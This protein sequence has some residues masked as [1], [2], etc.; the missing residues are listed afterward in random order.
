MVVEVTLQNSNNYDDYEY[1]M[2]SHSSANFNGN[3]SKACWYPGRQRREG[4]LTNK[5][6]YSAKVV[7]SNVDRVAG[8]VSNG[9]GRS[10]SNNNR[11]NNKIKNNKQN[12]RTTTVST[13]PG[14]PGSRGRSRRNNDPNKDENMNMK[15]FNSRYPVTSDTIN[16]AIG[17]GLGRGDHRGGHRGGG[18]EA[19]T[20]ALGSVAMSVNSI[21][22]LS[23]QYD[24]ESTAYYSEMMGNSH[25]ASSTK[26]GQSSS[27]DSTPFYG[28]GLDR[29]VPNGAS[30]QQPHFRRQR[31]P[32]SIIPE[33]SESESADDGSRSSKNNN[34]E[35]QE[36]DE[37]STIDMKGG[38]TRTKKTVDGISSKAGSLLRETSSIA[39]VET[40]C[41]HR[42]FWTDEMVEGGAFACFESVARRTRCLP[43]PGPGPAPADS[44]SNRRNNSSTDDTSSAHN[45]DAASTAV[46]A[47]LIP[48]EFDQTN[49]DNDDGVTLNSVVNDDDDDDNLTTIEDRVVPT[50]GVACTDEQQ[51]WQAAMLQHAMCSDTPA[52]LALVSPEL[53]PP[54][55]HRLEN[56][57][58]EDFLDDESLT[59]LEIIP[60]DDPLL[61]KQQPNTGY[62]QV[63]YISEEPLEVY[64]DK[65][66]LRRAMCT[67]IRLRK[68]KQKEKNKENQKGNNKQKQKQTQTLA[69]TEKAKHAPKERPVRLDNST[70][71]YDQMSNECSV[72]DLSSVNYP[73]SLSA[74][75][76]QQNG[77]ILPTSLIAPWK[78][79]PSSNE[80]DSNEWIQGGLMASGLLKSKQRRNLK[81][82]QPPTSRE[83]E[84][85]LNFYV[86][87]E[88]MKEQLNG[89][90]DLE[91]L[92]KPDG[93]RG[94][95]EVRGSRVASL[96]D[97]D[98]TFMESVNTKPANK[99]TMKNEKNQKKGKEQTGKRKGLRLPTCGRGSADDRTYRVSY[100]PDA[101]GQ[102]STRTGQP[103]ASTNCGDE[104]EGGEENVSVHVPLTRTMSQ[105][106]AM[107]ALEL[108]GLT[109][110]KSGPST[111]S[112]NSCVSQV[113][114]YDARD[115][116]VPLPAN[117]DVSSMSLNR[118]GM[119]MSTSK[120]TRNRSAE[121]SIESRSSRRHVN[122][123]SGTESSSHDS[124]ERSNMS[125]NAS[126]DV[127]T[128]NDET[129]EWRE[130]EIEYYRT[131][132]QSQGNGSEQR[133]DPQMIGQSWSANSRPLGDLD[134]PQS[135]ILSQSFE[136]GGESHVNQGVVNFPDIISSL[137]APKFDDNFWQ[138][139]DAS[140][141]D[142]NAFEEFDNEQDS[143]FDDLRSTSNISTPDISSKGSEESERPAGSLDDYLEPPTFDL[144]DQTM[145]PGRELPK[146]Q[147]ITGRSG[148][149]DN[150]MR[151]ST[152]ERTERSAV[153]K[154]SVA[155]PFAFREEEFV[156]FD[157]QM[158]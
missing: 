135:P 81:L 110:D 114:E 87:V 31:S 53:V 117:G 43:G 10:S 52:T 22:D 116:T 137:D 17:G 102:P 118:S 73:P 133:Y 88:A 131:H 106:I 91:D 89:I 84:D 34:R 103:P 24:N 6:K 126:R 96:V 16:N 1:G 48:E 20:K 14:R 139:D 136:S 146:F 7:N 155:S 58:E 104:L 54:G 3:N 12:Y 47:T 21:A 141:L 157:A 77:G 156:D 109:Q 68:Q 112:R 4:K 27:T 40:N 99:N 35:R 78:D 98:S 108:S 46:S 8:G 113:S 95:D 64:Q 86:E 125:L 49:P 32:N 144:H 82:P 145:S 149:Y 29:R 9:R 143:I 121:M 124:Y 129:G 153:S 39:A 85:A 120:D 107:R 15:A 55:P 111:P 59:Q 90:K 5:N 128:T 132:G 50:S 25:A 80:V 100:P 79:C 38:S 127:G 140:G 130:S 134:V 72:T 94:D 75:R 158:I 13:A 76:R 142:T 152:T 42:Q 28:N 74:E 51:Q 69:S 93:N 150:S 30:E 18:A 148:N 62:S 66:A 119:D 138:E 122:R 57:E 151:Y 11:S 19:K 56:N 105:Q 115:G 33:E 60:R 41:A 36:Y 44:P 63:Q 23:S 70:K 101:A 45:D 147:E 92:Q 2:Y 83:E 26:T 97:N 154:S 65:N 37:D 123:S 71:E 61:K 67:N